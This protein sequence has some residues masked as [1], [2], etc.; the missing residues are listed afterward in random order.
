MPSKIRHF[1]SKIKEIFLLLTQ[2]CQE[3]WNSNFRCKIRHSFESLTND[4]VIF[5][6]YQDEIP[7]VNSAPIDEAET[8]KQ[9][10]Q[11]EGQAKK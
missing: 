5:V 3:F 4:Y 8:K 1:Y 2:F 10:K 11:K 6:E 9:K 7:F